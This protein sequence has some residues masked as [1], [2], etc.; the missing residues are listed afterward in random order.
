MPGVRRSFL[1]K[2]KILIIAIL[3][4]LIGVAFALT[5]PVLLRSPFT[6]ACCGESAF[7]VLNPLRNRDVESYA[8]SVL[9]LMRDKPCEQVVANMAL[10]QER[11]QY[12]CEKQKEHPLLSWELKDRY[13]EGQQHILVY[14]IRYKGSDYIGRLLMWIENRNGE[15]QVTG[16]SPGG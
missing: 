14:H 7:V 15:W 16:Y 2:K 5:K 9:V 3:V 11:R 10:S 13:N 4:V 1:M 12:V 6:D 8:D